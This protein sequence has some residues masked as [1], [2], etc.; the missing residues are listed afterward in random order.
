MFS[1]RHHCRPGLLKIKI[2]VTC[3]VIYKNL[4]QVLPSQGDIMSKKTL[5]HFVIGL[6]HKP[7]ANV[8]G[9]GSFLIKSPVHALK[10]KNCQAVVLESSFNGIFLKEEILQQILP[11]DATQRSYSTTNNI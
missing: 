10:A 6:A 7:T 3:S 11:L 1:D 5:K 2:E 8:P 9:W 4:I